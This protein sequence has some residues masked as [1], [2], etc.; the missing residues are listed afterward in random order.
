MFCVNSVINPKTP[1]KN[2]TSNLCQS[3]S[4]PTNQQSN[5]SNIHMK[6]IRIIDSALKELKL[7]S[8]LLEWELKDNT[9]D[10]LKENEKLKKL[11]KQKQYQFRRFQKL[12]SWKEQQQQEKKQKN[13]K[14]DKPGIELLAS[15]RLL[16]YLKHV[17]EDLVTKIAFI[18]VFYH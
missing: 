3:S 7:E 10:L 5:Y 12:D 15:K 4:N 18:D 2:S 9:N 8:R 1:A 16:S 17:S 13:L 11:K 6:K 14:I